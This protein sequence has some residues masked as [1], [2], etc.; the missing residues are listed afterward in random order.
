MSKASK[1]KVGDRVVVNGHM[2]GKTFINATGVAKVVSTYAVGVEFDEFIDGLPFRIYG[3]PGHCWAVTFDMVK[4]ADSREEKS[5]ESIVIYRKGDKVVAKNKV[6]GEKATAKCHPEDE[7]DFIKGA[8]IAFNRL[9]DKEVERPKEL[10]NGKVICTDNE[11]ENHYTVGK[12][13]EVKN[14]VLVDDAGN[15]LYGWG[16]F[17]SFKEL[18]DFSSSKWLEVVE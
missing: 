1:I 12:I 10:Y 13:Y 8:E 9:L 3:K 16:G 6:T 11:A 17:R 18:A 4:K 7:F 5:E 2:H 14:G 15:E